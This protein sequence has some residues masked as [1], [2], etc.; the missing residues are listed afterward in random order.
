MFRTNP[1]I[2]MTNPAIFR[3][4]LV[5]FRTNPVIFRYPYLNHSFTIFAIAGMF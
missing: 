4:N 1:V 2:F 3:T 5:I